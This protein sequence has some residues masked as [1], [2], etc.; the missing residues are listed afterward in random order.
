MTV[1]ARPIK[2]CADGACS[3]PFVEYSD[4]KVTA[5]G[6]E[7]V[8]SRC[9]GPA[10]SAALG[11][12]SPDAP[13]MTYVNNC[14]PTKERGLEGQ[15]TF[16]FDLTALTAEGVVEKHVLAITLDAELEFVPAS[17]RRP[18]PYAE[19]AVVDPM[20]GDADVLA[21]VDEGEHAK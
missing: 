5:T 8:V 2:S 15:H 17:K 10:A 21:F 16:A 1:R 18:V 6:I 7:L 19:L 20:S 9:T 11:K 14:E 3:R 13:P 12:S 4:F